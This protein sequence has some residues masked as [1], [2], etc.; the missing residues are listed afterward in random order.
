[1]VKELHSIESEKKMNELNERYKTLE[2]QFKKLNDKL[3]IEK[4]IQTDKQ[5]NNLENELGEAKRKLNDS[6]AI[7]KKSLQQT[8]EMNDQLKQ[9]IASLKADMKQLNQRNEQLKNELKELASRNVE[10]IAEYTRKLDEKVKQLDKANNELAELE[11]IKQSLDEDYESQQSQ[12]K[13]LNSEVEAM[14]KKNEQLEHELKKSM[15]SD[16]NHKNDLNKKINEI[17]QLKNELKELEMTKVKL[18]LE[19][20]ENQQLMLHSDKE[21]QIDCA[22]IMPVK[23]TSKTKA[24]TKSTKTSKTSIMSSEIIVEDDSEDHMIEEK[25]PKLVEHTLH[26]STIINEESIALINDTYDADK[27]SK[28]Q[29]APTRKKSTLNR[30][31]EMIAKSP[32]LES[33]R[34]RPGRKTKAA[35]ISNAQ[36]K[37]I[38]AAA[39]ANDKK[40]RAKT[41]TKKTSLLESFDHLSKNDELEDITEIGDDSEGIAAKS[42]KKRGK[43]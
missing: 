25:K 10:Q 32:I 22:D 5:I 37:E 24:T 4:S 29:P 3:K 20:K 43:K 7:Y 19:L 23:K 6:E 8:N 36:D 26:R 16:T 42:R 35:T 31:T 27:I 38:I 13:A 9:Q 12:I 14:K 17:M 40:S 28:L 33:V 11:E 1:M 21:N 30:I 18:Q 34:N 15:Q 39:I 2:N 41:V